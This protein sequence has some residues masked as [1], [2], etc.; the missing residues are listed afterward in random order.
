MLTSKER[1]LVA[2]AWAAI[3]ACGAGG[4]LLIHARPEPQSAPV[5]RP[6]ICKGPQ[7][8]WTNTG[9][10]N[11]LKI[12][13]II[14]PVRAPVTPYVACILPK[15]ILIEVKGPTPIEKLLPTLLY[16]GKVG[17]DRATLA[18]TWKEPKLLW[19]REI[20]QHRSAPTAIVIHRQCDG[21]EIEPIA[22]LDPKTTSFEDRGV[23]PNRSYRYWALVRGEE[24]IQSYINSVR[25][26][27]HPGEGSVEGTIPSW[28]KVKL[29]GGDREHAILNLESYLPDKSVWEKKVVRVSPGEKIGATGWTLEGLRFDKFTLVAD[30]TDDRSEKREISTKD[31]KE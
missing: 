1:W 30:V 8:P 29:I 3:I 12:Q 17:M 6:T 10:V 19:S 31:K 9:M 25:T 24:G 14:S 16:S 23:Q 26:V 2:G 18:W 22:V 28:H 27:D 21:E 11:L 13:E 5:S 4:A 7:G 15:I 20:I